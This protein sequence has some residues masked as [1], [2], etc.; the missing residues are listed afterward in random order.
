MIKI[1]GFPFSPEFDRPIQR[2]SRDRRY[3]PYSIS[4]EMITLTT[5]SARIDLASL[6]T[7]KEDLKI[8]KDE[9]KRELQISGSSKTSEIIEG[10]KIESAHNWKRTL[11]VPK[12]VD[13]ESLSSKFNGKN[14]LFTADRKY[15]TNVPVSFVNKTE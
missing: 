12:T 15:G 7:Q 2:K 11:S 3:Q 4:Q 14:L 6:P 1:A 13:F 8:T 9:S 5:W 10:V